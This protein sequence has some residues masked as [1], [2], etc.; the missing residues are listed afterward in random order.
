MSWPSLSG[1]SLIGMPCFKGTSYALLVT[2]DPV[3]KYPAIGL[4]VVKIFSLP[5]LGRHISK[6][7]FIGKRGAK[8]ILSKPNVVLAISLAI[9][10][11]PLVVM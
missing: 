1:N 6:A 9:S 5:K 2:L 3:P 7:S 4:S 8:L 11:L 10:D